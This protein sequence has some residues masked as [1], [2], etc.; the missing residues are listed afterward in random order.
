MQKADPF[1]ITCMDM[2]KP[3]AETNDNPKWQTRF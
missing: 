3:E 2:F 1:N